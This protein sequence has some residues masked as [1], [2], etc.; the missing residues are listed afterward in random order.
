[1]R[2]NER[3]ARAVKNPPKA[4]ETQAKMIAEQWASG[5]PLSHPTIP[6][7][8]ENPTTRVLLR[9]GWLKFNGN[10]I[11]YPNGT[12]AAEYEVSKDGL[13]ALERHLRETRMNAALHA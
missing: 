11:T 1:M 4:T 8:Y 5:R 9:N 13:A 10:N 7:A 3:I 12:P 2:V 6:G